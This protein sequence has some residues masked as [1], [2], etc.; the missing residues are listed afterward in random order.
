MGD[1]LLASP[2]ACG[3]EVT[4][5]VEDMGLPACLVT[6]ESLAAIP[7]VQLGASA[8][9][10]SKRRAMTA[11][12][13]SLS[14]AARLK[15]GRNLQEQFVKGTKPDS[16][17]YLNDEVIASGLN[18]LGVTLGL[19]STSV[20]ESIAYIK[21][22]EQNRLL[23]DNQQDLKSRVFAQEEKEIAEE[24]EI[25]RVILNNLC[26]DIMDEVL[27]VGSE[28]IVLARTAHGRRKSSSTNRK[29]KNKKQSSP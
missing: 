12:E 22:I 10:S 2:V 4:M 28:Q 9:R 25:D 1:N 17:L 20:S 24:E 19:D 15:A 13:D 18:N 5:D 29:S 26:S 27:D 8:T 21:K 23:E 6:P 11:D 7:E 3:S 14:R 16:F